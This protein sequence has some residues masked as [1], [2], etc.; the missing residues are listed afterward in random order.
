MKLGKQTLKLD[1]TPSIL[2]AAC[3]GGPKEKKGPL[4]SYF[5][6]TV[7]DVFFCEKT[8]EKAESKFMY[9]AISKLLQKTNNKI[10]DID[11]LFAGDLLNQCIASGY[12]IRDLDVPF[13]GLYG[14]CSTMV[15]GLCLASLFVDSGYST[16]TIATTSSHYCSAER[17]FRL[18]LEQGGQK[19]PTS[20]W[21]VTGS[22]AALVGVKSAFPYVTYITTG[23]VIDYGIKDVS[24][25]G[26]AMAPAAVDTIISHFEDTGRKPDYYDLIV[27]GDLGYLGG[28]IL[29]D[30]CLKNGYDISKNF[31]DCGR[32]IYGGTNEDAKSGASGCGCMR[33]CILWIFI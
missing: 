30:I 2:N 15:E 19:A 28:D 32:L 8:F 1:N 23:K 20:Q 22:G 9:E 31:D 26:A 21:T 7:D 33:N 16:K 6:I 12:A 29:Q 18:P 17:Q 14:A 5:D 4:S 25:M 11:Y 3:T 10:E 27:T 13:F 24:N